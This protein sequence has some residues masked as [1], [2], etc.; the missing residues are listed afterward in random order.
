ML[1]KTFEEY[2]IYYEVYHKLPL[3]QVNYSTRPLNEKQLLTKYKD[4]QKKIENMQSKQ[5]QT[6]AD[7]MQSDSVSEYAKNVA[8]AMEQSKLSDPEHIRW[9]TFFNKLSVSEKHVITSNMWMCPKKDSKWVFDTAHIIERGVSSK[10]ADNIKN[11]IEIPRA[12]HHYID[13]Y[14]NPLTEEHEMLSKTEHDQLWIDLIGQE[15]WDW[16]QA[17]K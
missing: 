8:K 13:M 11:M 16:L 6:K 9:N 12:F 1:I 5:E 2:K 10:L 15:L 3:P 14:R 17:N 4:Y 7:Y